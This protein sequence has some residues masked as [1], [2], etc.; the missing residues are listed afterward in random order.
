MCNNKQPITIVRG[1]TLPLSVSITDA[2]G[3]AYTLSAGETLRFGVKNTPADTEYIFSKEMTAN[4]DDGDG[5]Y[6]FAI[7][8]ADT[9]ELG[10]GVY[11]YDIGLQNGAAYY[12]VIPA[13]EFNVAY[14]ITE[15]E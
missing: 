2:N 12:N 8:P 1:T 10:F 15:A 3:D 7:N 5:N 14:N 13:S 6:C 11:W 9:I 4:D